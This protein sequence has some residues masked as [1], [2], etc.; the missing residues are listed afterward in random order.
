MAGVTTRV[1]VTLQADSCTEP[2]SLVI[3]NAMWALLLQ[4]ALQCHNNGCLHGADAC[5][6]DF[7][8]IAVAFL[9][10]S[11]ISHSQLDSAVDTWSV[12]MSTCL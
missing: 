9:S 11:Y 5:R 12:Y 10:H 3:P 7:G 1:A 8:S 6:V 4:V 2:A